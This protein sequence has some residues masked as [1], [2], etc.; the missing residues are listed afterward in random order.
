MNMASNRIIFKKHGIAST[1]GW[2]EKL[3]KYTASGEEF[4]PEGMNA[5]MYGIPLGTMIKVTNPKTGKPG[6]T[7]V[8]I[9][10]LS[11]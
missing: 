3:N 1:Y 6:L 10:E 7:E 5:A 4:N 9:E 11:A 8:D 2:G